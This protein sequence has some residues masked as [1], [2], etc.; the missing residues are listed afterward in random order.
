MQGMAHNEDL[1]TTTS[2]VIMRECP[3]CNKPTKGKADNMYKLYVQIGGGAYFCHRCGAKGSW[4]DFKQKLSGFEVESNAMGLAGNQEQRTGAMSSNNNHN[5]N[6]IQNNNTH[7][8]YAKKQRSGKNNHTMQQVNRDTMLHNTASN[9]PM[10]SPK[11]QATYITNLLDNR[12]N[13][14]ASSSSS[15]AALKYLTEVRGLTKQTLRKFGVGLGSYQFPSIEPG[16]HNRFVS[17]DC[18]T[19]PWIMKASEVH[20]QETLRGGSFKVPS[21]HEKDNV[22]VDSLQDPFV[23]RRIKARSLS[24]KGNQR[25]DPPG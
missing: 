13:D 12:S 24:N 2:H 19:F 1:R 8:A 3:F 20:E 14:T 25:L 4:F 7:S 18:I 9:L 11:L 6:Y 17:A 5:N 22:N 23:T 10:P 16:Q 21:S 15:D